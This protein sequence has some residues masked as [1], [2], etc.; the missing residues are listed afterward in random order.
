MKNGLDWTWVRAAIKA[1]LM[2]VRMVKCQY[3]TALMVS[4][5]C[6]SMTLFRVTWTLFG[7]GDLEIHL[8]GCSE[9][10]SRRIKSLRFV[11]IGSPYV[12][13][14]L[15]RCPGSRFTQLSGNC[16]CWPWGNGY[17]VWNANATIWALD[18]NPS[19]LV[20]TSQKVMVNSS[21][22]GKGSR[23]FLKKHG[24]ASY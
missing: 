2:A 5:E 20:K 3:S 17:A 16:F 18:P 21:F 10:I 6:N 8:L 7:K 4:T 12:T 24:P 23:V 1:Y 9:K 22:F 13:Q 19:W 11:P 15:W 14:V